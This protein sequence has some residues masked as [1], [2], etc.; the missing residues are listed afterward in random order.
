MRASGA[1]HG[2]YSLYSKPPA[3]T[4]SPGTEV[5]AFSINDVAGLW[6]LLA[7]GSFI[8]FLTIALVRLK[9]WLVIRAKA[10]HRSLSSRE[11]MPCRSLKTRMLANFVRAMDEVDPS[12][13]EVRG[14][15]PRKPGVAGVPVN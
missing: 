7:I 3:N 11:Q 5:V 14:G 13:V 12:G 1:A 4:C 15:A 6:I 10:A 2:L 8:S 9:R